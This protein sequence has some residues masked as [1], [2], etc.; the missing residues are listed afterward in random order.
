M[1]KRI[2]FGAAL[3]SLAG[4]SPSSSSASLC[5]SALATHP[6]GAPWIAPADDTTPV[7][8][9]FTLAIDPQ[10]PV[11]SSAWRQPQAHALT[12]T[13]GGEGLRLTGGV[14][15]FATHAGRLYVE[16]YLVNDAPR[17]LAGVTLQPSPPTAAARRSR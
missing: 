6:T 9:T 10:D 16:L 14:K 17:G 12:V 1:W 2:A 11:L 7:A 13:G 15:S 8:T 5:P 3:S 4:C